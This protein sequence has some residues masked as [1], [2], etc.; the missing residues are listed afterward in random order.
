M[1]LSRLN[2]S[3]FKKDTEALLFFFVVVMHFSCNKTFIFYVLLYVAKIGSE[4][5][6]CYPYFVLLSLLLRKIEA[7]T[8]VYLTPRSKRKSK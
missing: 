7:E 4:Q 6:V 8:E 2:K 1:G 5:I 3:N